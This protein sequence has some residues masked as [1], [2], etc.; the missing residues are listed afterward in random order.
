M[1]QALFEAIA[2]GDAAAVRTLAATASPALR[3]EFGRP[4]LSAAASR[5]GTADVEVLRALLDAG[6]DVNAVQGEDS[7][8]ETGW[9]ALHQVCLQGT[10]PNAIHAARLLLERGAT[11]NGNTKDGGFS[12]LFFALKTH[13]LGIAEAL[14]K[15]GADANAPFKTGRPLHSLVHFYRERKTGNYQ[16]GEAEAMA[17]DAVTLLLAHGA[18]AA[19]RDEQGESALAKALLH[20]LP[21]EFVL[22]LIAAGAPLDERVDLG[23]KPAT[24]LVSPAAMAIGLGQPVEVLVAML[25][26]GID[27]TQP[28]EPDAQ[29]LLHYAAM[30]RNDAVQ[31]ILQLRPEQDVNP[32]D[33]SGAT[34]LFL[35]AWRGLSASVS[36]L[37]ERGAN[38]D[39]ADE[40]GNTPLHTAARNGHGEVIE[41]LL[42]AGADARLRN[43]AGESAAD[44]A[45]QQGHTQ[46]AERLS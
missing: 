27:T 41:L 31:S 17:T 45:R 44:R 3:D 18:D 38:P 30:K 20:K 14:L 26:R 13:H 40:G 9:T 11:P 1:S 42:A 4:P 12:P 23:K 29:N 34:A 25:K 10:F 28:T 46:L 16:P 32:R 6:A 22:A 2:R 19:A 37:L 7:D 8:E 36:A 15:A 35:A 24:L 43:A 5:A 21:A 39:L 33:D